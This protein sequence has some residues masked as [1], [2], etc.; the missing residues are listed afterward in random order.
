LKPK[1]SKIRNHVCGDYVGYAARL[2]AEIINKERF[3]DD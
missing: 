2:T 3:C 1:D